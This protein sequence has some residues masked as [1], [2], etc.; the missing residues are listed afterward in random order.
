VITIRKAMPPAVPGV[1]KRGIVMHA[2]LWRPVGAI[3]AAG[4]LALLGLAGGSTAAAP[5][6]ARAAGAATGTTAGH[7][8]DY[9]GRGQSGG[10]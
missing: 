4:T 9:R 2:Q 6:A 1:R 10:T 8:T 3:T 5:A 7:I